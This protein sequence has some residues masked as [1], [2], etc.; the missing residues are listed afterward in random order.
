MYLW[1]HLYGWDQRISLL[2]STGQDWSPLSRRYK[3]SLDD[4]RTKI[5]HNKHNFCNISKT[6]VAF[7]TVTRKP[8]SV[9]G[10]VTLDGVKWD[11]DCNTCHCSNGKVVCTKVCINKLC[12]S[13]QWSDVVV[14]YLW[15][16][17]TAVESL[18]TNS[19]RYVEN[20]RAINSYITWR[21]CGWYGHVGPQQHFYTQGGVDLGVSNSIQRWCNLFWKD[22]QCHCEKWVW[23]ASS[24]SPKVTLGED[25]VTLSWGLK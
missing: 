18:F 4:K 10:H 17:C 5:S 19:R 12:L 24:Q 1:L 14:K 16:L 15:W 7:N 13:S 8:C 6:A 25:W 22:T 21:F 20:G 11:E 3:S 23:D 2:M 9:N